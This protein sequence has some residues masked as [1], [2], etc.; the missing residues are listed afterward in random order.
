[1]NVSVLLCDINLDDTRPGR[2]GKI[3]RFLERRDK[4]ATDQNISSS[5]AD[6]V[7]SMIDVTLRMNGNN[8]FGELLRISTKVQTY[9][10]Y[11]ILNANLSPYNFRDFYF[12]QFKIQRTSKCSVS[13]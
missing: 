11:E 6:A 9:F 3:T 5:K 10:E 1:M 2:E 13:I 4:V 8:I 7:K 12:Y